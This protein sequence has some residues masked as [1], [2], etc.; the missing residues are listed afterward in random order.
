MNHRGTGEKEEKRNKS[1]ELKADEKLIASDLSPS[2][3]RKSYSLR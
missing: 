1:K 2:T 3:E